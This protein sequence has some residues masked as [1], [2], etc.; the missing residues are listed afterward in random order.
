[1]TAAEFAHHFGSI[2]TDEEFERQVQ[3]VARRSREG[4]PFP[5]WDPTAMSSTMPPPA[6]GEALPPAEP[7]SPLAQGEVPDSSS[8]DGNFDRLMAEHGFG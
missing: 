2:L 1:M 7:T 8:S 4:H 3:E 5:D 6:H